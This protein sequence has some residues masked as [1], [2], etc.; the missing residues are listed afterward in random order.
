MQVPL[1]WTRQL[2]QHH[3]L[4]LMLIKHCRQCLAVLFR[5]QKQSTMINLTSMVVSETETP[6]STTTKI[7]RTS[8]DGLSDITIETQKQSTLFLTMTTAPVTAFQTIT[9]VNS[10]QATA[11]VSTMVAAVS[12][13]IS[14]FSSS[15]LPVL[16]TGSSNAK[17]RWQYFQSFCISIFSCYK[18][19]IRLCVDS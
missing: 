11:A 19:R 15:T 10:Q 8:S 7:E 5:C 16:Q 2:H 3:L 14:S 13:L 9:V 17:K 18:Q 4:Q 12:T 1:R 6:E